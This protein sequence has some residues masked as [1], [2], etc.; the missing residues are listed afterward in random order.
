MRFSK[1]YATIFIIM[2]TE[3]LGFSL[4]LPFLPFYVEKLGASPLTFGLILTSFSLF[5]FLSAPIMGKLSDHYGRK[6]LL[7]FSQLSTFL[8]FI[9]LGFANTIW[10]VF[11][12]RI[13]DGILG[14]NLTIAQ[15]YLSD[16][17]T[18]KNRSKAFGISGAAFGVGFL[19]GPAI[20]GTLAKISYS[21]PCF[22]AAGASLTTI[23][24]T[25]FFLEETVKRKKDIKLDLRIF[26]LKEFKKYFSDDRISTK[27]M[28]FFSYVLTHAI[29][30]T[31]F[32]YFAQRVLGFDSANIGLTLAYVGVVSVI[33]RGFL[34]SKLIDM[35]GEYWLQYTGVVF[36]LIAMILIIFLNQWGVFLIAMT[37]FSTG[38]G[39]SRPLLMGEISRSVSSKEQGAIMG[40]AGSLGSIAQIFGPLIGNAMITYFF[41][42]SLGIAAGLAI[43]AALLLKL[44][45]DLKA[46]TT[47]SNA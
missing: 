5:Q 31:S 45:E 13:V 20:G 22:I 33:L 23:L 17:S 43:A 24:T 15:A 47:I 27:L 19:I 3:V 6:P 28:Q 21:L 41:P 26:H 4:I 46:R 36:V 35:F 38:S 18:E 10:L 39:L 12:S 1:E 42:G 16:I 29:Y 25:Y 9:I 34:L 37:L 32:A 44:R 40:V 2:V 30:V 14:S 8:S 7:I 11:L